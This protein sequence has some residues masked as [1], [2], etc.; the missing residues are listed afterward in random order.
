MEVMR[1]KRLLSFISDGY[2]GQLT[3]ADVLHTCSQCFCVYVG[4]THA[5][6]VSSTNTW[7]PTWVPPQTHGHFYKHMGPSKNA[8]APLQ[9]QTHEGPL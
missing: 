3:V 5:H 2:R 9:T 1:K 7:G 4:P 8:W 6:K